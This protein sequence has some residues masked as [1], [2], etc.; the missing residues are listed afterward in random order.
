M[1]EYIG[2]KRIDC[3]DKKIENEMQETRPICVDK[4][5]DKS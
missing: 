3:V 2:Y 5:I 4:I 1:E